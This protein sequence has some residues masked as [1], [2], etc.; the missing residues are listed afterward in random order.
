[1][2]VS[3]YHKPILEVFRIVQKCRYI[4]SVYDPQGSDRWIDSKI[5]V[6]YIKIYP[7]T[8]VVSDEMSTHFGD[9]LDLRNFVKASIFV[10]N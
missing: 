1:M 8:W 6:G 7:E 9:V 2:V 10:L 4:F 3:I 5:F